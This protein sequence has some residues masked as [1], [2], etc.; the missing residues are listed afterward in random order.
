MSLTTSKVN[1]AIQQKINDMLYTISTLNL[2]KKDDKQKF[3]QLLNNYSKDPDILYSFLIYE[4][5]LKNDAKY[6]STI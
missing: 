1:P 6:L 2:R 3:I 4:E 5:E